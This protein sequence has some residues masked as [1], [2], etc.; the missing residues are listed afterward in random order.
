ME[1]KYTKIAI[2]GMGHLGK[3]LKRGLENAKNGAMLTI[4]T[5]NN[6]NENIYLCSKNYI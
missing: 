2:I 5:S 1:N 4:Q 6:S 3:A